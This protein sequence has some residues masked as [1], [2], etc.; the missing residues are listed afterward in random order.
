MVT[1]HNIKGVHRVVSKKEYE[2]KRGIPV[3]SD[4]I[5]VFTN[6]GI[7]SGRYLR[8][9]PN[10][11]VHLNGELVTNY[12]DATVTFDHI[13]LS[14]LAISHVDERTTPRLESQEPDEDGMVTGW[15]GRKV[16]L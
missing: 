6:S 1:H 10:H 13:P 14:P 9:R 4:A 5:L 3:P 16:W 12:V 7:G 2:M 15:D 8:F 11:K